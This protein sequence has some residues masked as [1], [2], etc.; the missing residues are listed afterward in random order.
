MPYFGRRPNR[1]SR[2]GRG[3]PFNRYGEGMTGLGTDIPRSYNPQGGPTPLPPPGF[4]VDFPGGSRKRFKFA[5]GKKAKKR[6]KAKRA[7]KSPSCRPRA[8]AVCKTNAR[9]G[10]IKSSCKKITPRRKK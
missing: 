6:K 10:I 9:G 1:F 5:G 8:I 7:S 4:E 3:R 2:F